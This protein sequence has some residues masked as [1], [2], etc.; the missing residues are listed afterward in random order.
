MIKKYMFLEYFRKM[1]IPTLN[2]CKEIVK[3]NDDM[4]FYEISNTINGYAFSLFGYR[5]AK[6]ENFINSNALELKGITFIQ[7]ETGSWNHFLMLNK[8]WELDQY[9]HCSYTKFKDLKIKNVYLKEDGSLISFIKLPDGTILPKTKHGFD[10]DICTVAKDFINKNPIYNEF[11]TDL[12]NKNLIPSFEVVGKRTRIIVK[13]NQTNLILL[14][15]RDNLTG[16]YIDL[17]EIHI[18][19]EVTIAKKFGFKTL[20]EVIEAS[21]IEKN[22]EGWVVQ[23]MDD[24]L[25]KV[26]TDWYNSQEKCGKF[27]LLQENKII[28]LILNEKIDD[29]VSKLE[30]GIDDDIRENVNLI[31]N[32]LSTYIKCTI[33]EL[34]TLMKDFNGDRKEFALKYKK[35]KLFPLCMMKL[36]GIDEFEIVKNYI[37][38]ETSRLEL[39]K[40]FLKFF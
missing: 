8:F 26:K 27:E 39:A 5:L 25:L 7:N 35:N 28:E 4:V 19:E 15:V 21:K 1:K 6:Y 10:N 30:F 29:A 34:N 2:E 40:E 32:K 11:I 14:R 31:T 13:Y 37:L 16:D 22:I 18:P 9:E 23:F 38:K 17:S 24:S 33:N 12:M 20:D 36:K 3:N